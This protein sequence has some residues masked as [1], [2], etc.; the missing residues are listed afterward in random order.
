MEATLS[1]FFLRPTFKN[2]WCISL[3]TKLVWNRINK[4]QQPELQ[5]VRLDQ[6]IPQPNYILLT[7]C[8]VLYSVF[9]VQ[10]KVASKVPCGLS[11]LHVTHTYM[12]AQGNSSN[13]YFAGSIW[14]PVLPWHF[15]A[16][17]WEED[18]GDEWRGKG[19]GDQE[20]RGKEMEGERGGLV[21]ERE[22]ERERCD[23]SMSINLTSHFSRH[24]CVQL[25]KCANVH[26]LDVLF[27]DCFV[28]YGRI[29]RTVA[30][31]KHIDGHKHTHK[32]A[33]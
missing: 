19:G 12:I 5:P 33:H 8:A 15:T 22:R 29:A 17:G 24:V 10:R 20:G 3:N 4:C 25:C 7:L 32:P 27:C 21:R 13:V 30:R 23:W 26:V 1:Y 28:L 31:G 2:T 16:E 11:Y 18:R 9:C 14:P 6:Q